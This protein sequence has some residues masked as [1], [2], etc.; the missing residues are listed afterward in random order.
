MKHLFSEDKREHFT[1]DGM[2]IDRLA[3]EAL[4]PIYELA[5]ARGYSIRE[6]QYIISMS[7][8]DLSLMTLL[9]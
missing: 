3:S 6:V 8:L 5:K 2:E 1:D 4:A 9:D 7:S